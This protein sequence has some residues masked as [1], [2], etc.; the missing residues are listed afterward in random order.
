MEKTRTI[1]FVA[2]IVACLVLLIHKAHRPALVPTIQATNIVVNAFAQ[3]NANQT[4]AAK[5]RKPLVRPP[6]MDDD[7][8]KYMFLMHE[9]M[10]QV[11]RPIEFYARVV[12]QAGH[13]VPDV[14][15]ELHLFR[16]NED[17]IEEKFPNVDIGGIQAFSTNVLYSDAKGWIQLNGI[18]GHILTV[19]TLT[20]DGY[21]SAHPDGNYGGIEYKTNA[22]V[23]VAGRDEVVEMGCNT[24]S[25]D[26]T[27][28]ALDPDKGHTFY[29]WKKGET[30][31]LV[32]ADFGYLIKRD[33]PEQA[34]SLFPVAKGLAPYP[35]LIIKTSFVHPE[36]TEGDR[37]YDRWIIIEAGPDAGIQET[38]MTYPYLAPQDGY[39]RE[40]K[41]MYKLGSRESEGW[42]RR[43][44]VK[45]RN[46][47][48]FA[49]MTIQFSS[50]SGL[51]LDVKTVI[52]PTG[53]RNLEPDP[54]KL[55]TD[56]AE[57]R[58]IDEATRAK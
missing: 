2:I 11:N 30:E 14:R 56:P 3:T 24:S 31:K 25:G 28:D 44:H 8:W 37:A 17:L 9:L 35:D 40:F 10:F 7:T 5:K 46:G 4:T 49:A 52:N 20:R 15:V 54:A 55:I 57:I 38:P 26:I 41:F 19:W 12:D 36:I 47:K 23:N 6:G 13:P 34:V 21:E 50:D 33:M 27:M 29:L 16:Q 18:T 39:G 45:A 53:S 1:I 42:T 48:L 43:F 51:T 32:Q 58:Q 22:V